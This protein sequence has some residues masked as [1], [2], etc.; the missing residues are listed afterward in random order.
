MQ[1]DKRRGTP[2]HKNTAKVRCWP[3]RPESIRV[4]WW[5]FEVVAWDS[6]GGR[7]QWCGPPQKIQD[8][9]APLNGSKSD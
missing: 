7:W 9:A 2:R 3:D 1:R 8:V 5:V 4:R 6:R